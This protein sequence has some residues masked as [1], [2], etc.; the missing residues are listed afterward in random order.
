MAKLA[1]QECG[2]TFSKSVSAGSEPKCPKCGGYDVDL[3]ESTM[4]TKKT[5]SE[6]PTVRLA[7]AIREKRYVD[8]NRLFEQILDHKVEARLHEER[9]AAMPS[10]MKE[11]EDAGADC[12]SCGKPLGECN[13]K[14]MKESYKG[15]HICHIPGNAGKDCPGCKG[16][17]K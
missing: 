1:C 2:H 3:A 13:C 12:Q 10:F 15:D 14:R 8:A 5:I 7:R 9:R 11:D 4:P 17:K 16:S 6:A